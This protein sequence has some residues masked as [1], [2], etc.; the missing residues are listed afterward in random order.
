MATV[1]AVMDARQ[2]LNLARL[3]GVWNMPVS[4]R[5]FLSTLG[6]EDIPDTER[7]TALMAKLDE[8]SPRLGALA[9]PKKGAY[10]GS[11]HLS[12]LDRTSDLG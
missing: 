10:L 5:S 3:K 11:S 6:D 12:D 1:L 4:G 8:L 9:A 7:Q 2:D